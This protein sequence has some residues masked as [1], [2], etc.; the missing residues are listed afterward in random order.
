MKQYYVYI[1]ASDKETL[2][3]WITQDL[4]KRVYQHKEKQVEWFTKKYNCNKLVYYEIHNDV[5]EA[6]KREK[7][8]K[9]WKREW[10][11]NLINEKNILWKDLYND[12]IW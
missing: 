11:I 4:I 5:N 1:M 7:Q 6:I 3:I 10:K 8:I 2:Y 12:L 9:R